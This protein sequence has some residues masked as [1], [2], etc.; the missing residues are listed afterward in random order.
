VEFIG[1]FLYG[2]ETMMLLILD[3]LGTFVFALSGAMMGVRKQLDL[4][5]VFV[6]SFA[7]GNAGGIARDVFIGTIPPSAI[8]DWKYVF[9]SVLAGLVVFYR[10]HWIDR[11][12]SSVLVFDGAGLALFAVNGTQKALN[13]GLAP[14]PAALLGMLSGIGG[15]MLRDILCNESPAVLRADFYATAALVGAIV[16]VLGYWLQ[17]PPGPVA[18]AGAICC[19]AIRLAALRSGWKLPT[20]KI[21]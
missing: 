1:R 16:V 10:Y 6:L 14:I 13:H 2:Y 21:P 12:R 8:D 3:L 17:I 7:A 5:G 4:F 15:G 20:A 19:F 18:V 9:V 11:L